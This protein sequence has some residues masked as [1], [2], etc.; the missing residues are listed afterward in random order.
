MFKVSITSSAER[1]LKRLDRPIKNRIVSAILALASD[2]RPPGCLKIKSE[3]G[4]WRI[5]V[6][7]WRVG[8]RVDDSASEV[9]V[10]KIAHRSDF[11]E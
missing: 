2:P 8:Y 3:E 1:D 11:Y 4:V 5:R 10:L 6:G 7:D 9:I